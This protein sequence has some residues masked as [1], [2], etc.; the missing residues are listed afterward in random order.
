MESSYCVLNYLQKKLKTIKLNLKNFA[1]IAIGIQL[2]LPP[3]KKKVV[4][5]SFL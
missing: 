4:H 3:T 2:K 1:I 5:H